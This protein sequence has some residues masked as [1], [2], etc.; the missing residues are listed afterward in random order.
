MMMLIKAQSRW[1]WSHVYVIS[2]G[3]YLLIFNIKTKYGENRTNFAQRL[4]LVLSFRSLTWN[5]NH[6]QL[7]LM[8]VIVSNR[9][10]LKL[11]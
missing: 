9:N 4:A 3:F 6:K 11:I 5:A 7:S 1:C 8:I 10:Q 2:M